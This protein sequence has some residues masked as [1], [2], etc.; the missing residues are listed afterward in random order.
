[1]WGAR[2]GVTPAASLPINT[3]VLV[4]VRS[5]QSWRPGLPVERFQQVG[6]GSAFTTVNAMGELYDG[7]GGNRGG[8]LEG[9]SPQVEGD[10]PREYHLL[11]R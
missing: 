6:N 3:N 8:H 7:V 2:H 4:S 10:G 5:A 9:Q 1:V 11:R